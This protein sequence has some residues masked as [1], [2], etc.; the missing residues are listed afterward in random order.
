M[1]AEVDIEGVLPKE[2]AL[3]KDMLHLKYGQKISRNDLDHIVA[4][5]YGTQAYD[6]VTYEL[7]GDAEPF[8]LVFKC[9]KG[10]VHQLG[11]GCGQIPRKSYRCCLIWG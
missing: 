4:R 11:V 5:I 3:I 10:P 9:R 2:K 8:K 6:Y 7:L 1:I